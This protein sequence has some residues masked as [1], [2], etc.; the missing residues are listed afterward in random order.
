MKKFLLVLLASAPLLAGISDGAK[1]KL[2]NAMGGAANEA[3]LGTLVAEGGER[4]SVTNGHQPHQILI[5]EYDFE[6]MS[7][8]SL[9]TSEL[10]VSLPDNAIITRS[11]LDVVTALVGGNGASITVSATKL[12]EN[13][14]NI[15]AGTLISSMSV[16]IK[17]GVS[18]GTAA[19][20]QKM[21]GAAG[22][23]LKMNKGVLT[24]GK[25]KVY[26][27]YVMGE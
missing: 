17:E 26:I 23:R 15:F 12:T 21:D 25:L 11:Y 7:G 8:S 2:N 16:G 3:Q 4:G 6:T 13:P 5:G 14:E 18:T 19:T 22:I 27:H 9:V 24:A 1:Y 10:G 20:M